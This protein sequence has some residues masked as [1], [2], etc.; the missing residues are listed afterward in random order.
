M[1]NVF[2]KGKT[3]EGNTLDRLQ[4]V[5]DFLETEGSLEDNLA[6][7]ATLA[8]TVFDAERCSIMLFAEGEGADMRLRVCAC[9]G[10]L[11]TEAYAQLVAKGEGIA[12]Q[13]AASG[14]ALL[15]K[16]IVASPFAGLARRATDAGRSLMAAPISV[17]HQVI[18]VMNL[19]S[20]RKASHFSQA[21]LTT[22]EIVA[23][24][25]GKTIQVIQLQNLLKS[26]FA[27]I[28][29]AQDAEKAIG[30]AMLATAYD[31]DKM[32]RI[33]AKSFFREMT[34]AGFGA[35]QII[36]AASEIISQ[37]SS[38]LNQHGKRLD[39]Q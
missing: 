12:G 27:Q 2:D 30:S 11:P 14:Q 16:D 32:S 17:N 8:A 9:H 20:P 22:L 26:R 21:D 18:G 6:Q 34:Q 37:L 31:P 33:V 36:Q 13:V 23:R 35:N 39:K 1:A 5:A 3:L 19:S 7:L 25:T 24:F 15:V 10:E 28:A 38:R 4:S 29:L